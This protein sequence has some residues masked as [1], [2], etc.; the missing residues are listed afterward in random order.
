MQGATGAL[1]VLGVV[2]RSHPASLIIPSHRAGAGAYVPPSTSGPSG[3][4]AGAWCS[5]PAPQSFW[6]GGGGG[7]GGT[8]R[9]AALPTVQL[10]GL[11]GWDASRTVPLLDL[12]PP[13]WAQP[14]MV[15]RRRVWSDRRRRGPV[16]RRRRRAP[17]PPPRQDLP[18]I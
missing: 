9:K 14:F 8:I 5:T 13:R 2:Q 6:G 10:L 7:G 11:L 4:G 15:P 12:H 3:S 17:G 18:D 16:H 1:C